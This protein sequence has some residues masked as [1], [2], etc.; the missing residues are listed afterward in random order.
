MLLFLNCFRHWSL[1]EP[2]IF[3]R[4][5]LYFRFNYTVQKKLLP[6]VPTVSLCSW[7]GVKRCR[8]TCNVFKKL[9]LG[10]IINA[11][12]TGVNCLS[13]HNAANFRLWIMGTNRK[14]Y[15]L[16]EVSFHSN[17][18]WLWQEIQTLWTYVAGVK[19]HVNAFHRFTQWTY[20]LWSIG[21]TA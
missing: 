21:L 4:Y 19:L 8:R 14:C 5:D 10:W 9:D 15:S 6:L 12:N 3:K 18:I 20:Q 16:C 2:G 11:K 17:K 13:W 1:F 7:L